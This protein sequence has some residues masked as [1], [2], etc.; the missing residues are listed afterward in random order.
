MVEEEAFPRGKSKHKDVCVCVCVFRAFVGFLTLSNKETHTTS[1]SS[2]QQYYGPHNFISL[3]QFFGVLNV[4]PSSQFSI[5]SY[6]VLKGFSTCSPKFPMC[7]STCSQSCITL[8]HTLLACPLGTSLQVGPI[9]RFLC[10]LCFG[11][12]IFHIGESLRV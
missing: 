11:V 6:H 7:S 3:G 9:L 12:N 2:K 4:F 5:G 10:F 8:S 1:C